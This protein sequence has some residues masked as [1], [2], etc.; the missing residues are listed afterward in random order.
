VGRIFGIA[1]DLG[2]RRDLRDAILTLA[3]GLGRPRRFSAVIDNILM[4]PFPYPVMPSGSIR[5]HPDSERSGGRPVVRRPEFLVYVRRIM[6]LAGDRE[7]RTDM[8]YR[9]GEGRTERFDGTS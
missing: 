3:L 4:E 6:R 8:L 5:V 7:R 2:R 9:S 1:E